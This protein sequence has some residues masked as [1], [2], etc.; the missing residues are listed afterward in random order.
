MRLTVL[1]LG[2]AVSVPDALWTS[3][4]AM[5]L[6]VIPDNFVHPSHPARRLIDTIPYVHA[7]DILNDLST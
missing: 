6:L 1:G 4:A 7:E 2:S 5:E 3:R